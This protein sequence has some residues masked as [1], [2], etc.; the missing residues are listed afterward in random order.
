MLRS[1]C[2]A[3]GRDYEEIIK[4]A[5]ADIFLFRDGEDPEHATAHIR[6][7]ASFEDFAKG[8]VVGTPEQV[9]AHVQALVEAG[10]D[11]V[12]VYMPGLALDR[13]PIERFASNVIPA[14]S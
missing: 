13:E 12:I 14:F 4:S 8:K 9:R 3:E 10:I 2:E 6:G 1:H 7:R 11:Y 5:E